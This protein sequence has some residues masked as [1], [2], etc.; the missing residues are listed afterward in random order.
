[1]S[2]RPDF[3]DQ[4]ERLGGEEEIHFVIPYPFLPP[5]FR[6]ISQERNLLLCMDTDFGTIGKWEG[7]HY[8]EWLPF[9]PRGAY[10]LMMEVLKNMRRYAEDCFSFAAFVEENGCIID[11]NPGAEDESSR[12]PDRDP[13]EIKTEKRIIKASV[14]IERDQEVLG[15]EPP[16]PNWR[17]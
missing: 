10:R 9:T 7:S 16:V 6:K 2:S 14:K 4:L 13:E 12:R 8:Q 3:S 15:G 17:F 5:R 11:S 1:M